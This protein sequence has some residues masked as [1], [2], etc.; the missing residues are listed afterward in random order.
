MD[1]LPVDIHPPQMP[2]SG[3]PYGTFPKPVRLSRYPL[4]VGR[5]H[6]RSK[7]SPTSLKNS[8]LRRASALGHFPDTLQL[9]PELKRVSSLCAPSPINPKINQ[10]PF[11]F[12]TLGPVLSL[13]LVER[14]EEWTVGVGDL[15]C[16][17]PVEEKTGLRP[18]GQHALSD[19]YWTRFDNCGMLDGL[20]QLLP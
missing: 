3:I 9:S 20:P 12:R 2:G 8:T 17:R 16:Q 14:S 13:S 19:G 5:A 15:R 10:T 4:D 1:R 18:C 7:P 11:R 6:Y